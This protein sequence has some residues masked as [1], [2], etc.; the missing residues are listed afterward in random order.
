MQWNQGL[1]Q[2]A[3]V[4]LAADK[5]QECCLWTDC[6]S[7]GREGCTFCV[8]K[9]TAAL[10][11]LLQKGGELRNC[12][13]CAG[14]R[15]GPWLLASVRVILNVNTT[16]GQLLLAPAVRTAS[17]WGSAIEKVCVLTE[18]GM[19]MLGSREA[20]NLFPTSSQPASLLQCWRENCRAASA[21]GINSVKS[22]NSFPCLS[23]FLSSPNAL[24]A[25]I[26]AVPVRSGRL[27]ILTQAKWYYFDAR[28]P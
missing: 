27:N 10:A 24:T 14:H 26:R 16:L 8:R 18:E 9:G 7:Y 19:W 28:N 4:L 6:E 17:C 21:H 13:G 3:E 12:F 2:R 1:L 20:G 23:S 11:L 22:L 5:L 25:M 15:P